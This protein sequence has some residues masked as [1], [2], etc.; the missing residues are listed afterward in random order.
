MKSED[1]N[2]IPMGNDNIK[3]W[4]DTVEEKMEEADIKFVIFLISKE[5]ND[6]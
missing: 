6:L 4:E 5:N 2:W 3:N 1:S